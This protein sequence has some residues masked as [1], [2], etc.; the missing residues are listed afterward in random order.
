MERG[1]HN[2]QQWV[3]KL[4]TFADVNK[5]E[6]QGDKV[7]LCVEMKGC[8]SICQ[9]YTSDNDSLRKSLNVCGLSKTC[10]LH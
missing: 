7:C 6:Q 4:K 3:N 8:S 1:R 10:L 5:A 2:K 9:I